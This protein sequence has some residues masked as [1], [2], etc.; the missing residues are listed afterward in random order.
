MPELPEVETTKTSLMPLLNHR[1]VKIETSGF[2]LR[3]PMADLSSLI[4]TRFIDVKRR[5]KYLFLQ[6]DKYGDTLELLIHLGMSG[7]LGQYLATTQPIRKHDHMVITFDHGIRLHYHDPRRFGMIIW[8]N[9]A[10]KYLKNIGP[11]PLSDAFNAQYLYHIIHK[12]K[13]ITRPIKSLIMEQKIVVGVGNIYATESLFLSKIHP[14]TPSFLLTLEQLEILVGHIKAI[15]VK[16]IEVGGSSLKD[17]SVGDN[18]TGY[19]Q[20]TLLAYGREGLPCPSCHLP[21]ESIK[22][23]GRASVFCPFCQPLKLTMGN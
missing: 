22:I 11:E 6:F 16:A 7:S 14:A 12:N 1:I 19:F 20:Q 5:A 10:Q 9:H 15:L 4:G 18:Q 23:V 17:F 2:R 3:E 8:K 13:P 21:M